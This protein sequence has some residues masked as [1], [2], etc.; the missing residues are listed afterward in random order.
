M[1]WLKKDVWKQ[2][3]DE[4]RLRPGARP[5]RSMGEGMRV[6]YI[7]SSRLL[8]VN[9]S[10]LMTHHGRQAEAAEEVGFEVVRPGR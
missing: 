10:R 9:I 4:Q 7:D 3:D 1:R 5:R 2:S 6:I 8:K